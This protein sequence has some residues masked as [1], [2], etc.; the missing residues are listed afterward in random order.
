MIV[1]DALRVS[2][3]SPLLCNVSHMGSNLTVKR[4]KKSQYIKIQ[5][6]PE[7]K[8]NYIFYEKKN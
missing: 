4:N 3:N 2:L 6:F 7:K 1:N 5:L 8:P